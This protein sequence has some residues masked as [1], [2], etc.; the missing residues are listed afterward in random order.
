MNIKEY[1][2]SN[3]LINDDTLPK[4]YKSDL[5]KNS[6][7]A[8]FPYLVLVL[9]ILLLI[10]LFSIMRVFKIDD[11]LLIGNFDLDI[12]LFIYFSSII[13][14]FV[15]YYFMYYIPSSRLWDKI[16][17]NNWFRNFR[18][19]DILLYFE[20]IGVSDIA[21]KNK[22]NNIFSSSLLIKNKNLTVDYCLDLINT[23]PGSIGNKQF[24]AALNSP[25]K[26]Q[27]RN[28]KHYSEY[29]HFYKFEFTNKKFK[30]T[31]NTIF[32]YGEQRDS[33][34]S[35]RLAI[36][37]KETENVFVKNK[38]NNESILELLEEIKKTI[39][40]YSN[41]KG[42]IIIL[43]GKVVIKV[44]DTIDYHFEENSKKISYKGFL[45]E[46]DEKFSFVNLTKL[47]GVFE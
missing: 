13:V 24:D 23:S 8:S 5:L 29:S 20:E 25:L 22:K 38:I 43:N 28:D 11:I 30:N 15:I 42:E 33:F 9:L 18:L 39:D 4:S 21:I 27:E 40:Q 7:Y 3:N 12:T 44:Y 19:Y 46:G 16:E 47:F 26:T 6:L 34:E 32:F 2:T 31:N 14:V 41:L 36:L 1:F 17:I 37:K 45:K 10:A 35:H